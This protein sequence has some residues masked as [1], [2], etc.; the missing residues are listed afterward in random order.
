MLRPPTLPPLAAR[1]RAAAGATAPHARLGVGVVATGLVL[2][3]VGAAT[4]A[5]M[6][7]GPFA[8]TASLKHAAPRNPLVQP[9]NIVG[10]YLVGTLVGVA[11]GLVFGPTVIAT[12]GT[13]ALAAVLLMALGV[14]HPPAIAM[15]VVAVQAPTAHVIQIALVG[16]IAMVLTMAALAPALHRERW[17]LRPAR[18]LADPRHG[19]VE[20]PR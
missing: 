18:S 5:S 7:I 14:E 19:A 15:A 3:G 11:A 8:A 12:I 6:I 20:P 13:A 9:R 2:A 16:A 4:H 1:A 17:P 10:G